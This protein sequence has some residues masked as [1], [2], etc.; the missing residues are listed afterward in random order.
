MNSQ[1]TRS[2]KGLD[3]R[4]PEERAQWE[5]IREAVAQKLKRTASRTAP[6]DLPDLWL[7]D[8]GYLLNELARIRGLV[9]AVPLTALQ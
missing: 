7:A 5:A 3:P 6:P 9:N 4:G 1:R 8:S 2:R